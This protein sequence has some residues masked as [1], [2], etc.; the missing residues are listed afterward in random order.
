[1]FERLP[2]SSSLGFF[3]VALVSA[4]GFVGCSST[5]L[6]PQPHDGEIAATKLG[7]AFPEQAAR[8]LEAGDELLVGPQG[9]VR[10]PNVLPRGAVHAEL[11][12]DGSHPIVLRSQGFE[13]RVKQ[14]GV[15]SEGVL[16]KRA[17]AYR[18]AGGTSYWTVSAEGAEEWLD[19]S[20]E[21]V[22]SDLPVASWEIEGGVLRQHEDLIEVLDA[23]GRARMRVTAP[24]AYG[25]DNREIATRLEGQGTT[26]ALYVDADGEDVLV[27]PHWTDA[28]KM[29]TARVQHTMTLLSSGKV[30]VVGGKS[31]TSDATALDTAEIYDPTVNTWTR[32]SSGLTARRA[33]TATLLENGKVL[34]VGGFPTF[35]SGTGAATTS[36]Q[37]YD[38]NGDSWSNVKELSAGRGGH[39]S[40]WLSNDRVMVAGGMSGNT[41]ASVRLTAVETYNPATNSWSSMGTNLATGRRF[42]TMMQVAD[43]T[44]V[45]AG[46]DTSSSPPTATVD[47]YSG[48]SRLSNTNSMLAGRSGHSAILL[49]SGKI[50]VTNGAV[51]GNSSAFGEVFTPPNTWTK[52][53]DMVAARTNAGAVLLDDDKVLVIGGGSGT[54]ALSSGEVYDPDSNGWTTFDAALKTARR[55]LKAV[56]LQDGR[57]LVAGGEDDAGVPL[58]SVEILDFGNPSCDA[59][60]DCSGHGTCNEIG[61]CDCS[62]GYAGDKCQY[63]D[64]TTCSGHGAAQ[65]DG[66]CICAS[67]YAGERCEGCG[68]GYYGYPN[69]QALGG[70]GAAC[71][72][73]YECESGR[74][75]DNRCCDSA[76]TGQCEA[77]DLPGREG[78]CSAVTGAPRHGRALCPDDDKGCAG[79][80]DGAKRNACSHPITDCRA[81]TDAGADADIDAGN[82]AGVPEDAGV[83]EDAGEPEDASAGDDAGELEDASA[84]ND[85]GELEDAS[86]GDDAGELEDA[87]DTEDAS[88]DAGEDAAPVDAGDGLDAESDASEEDDG[89]ALDAGADASRDAATDASDDSDSG[90][91]RRTPRG[92]VVAA[93]DSGCGCRTAGATTSPIA[94]WWSALPIAAV[95]ARRRQKKRGVENL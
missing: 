79:Y 42:P 36:V 24:V 37:I 48:T 94:W 25:K 54:V 3:F 62:A 66:S 90:R 21:H 23:K 46:G 49:K 92:D 7:L 75:V 34:V 31:T 18:R 4:S 95:F 59:A 26:L 6:S 43:G 73:A 51:A 78:I 57:V 61:R 77:C 84:D 11:P 8:V 71:A 68:H 67:G 56:K 2:R 65:A 52:T 87:G 74:C 82:D 27:D 58:D 38:P 30:L 41:G 13:L 72:M 55:G 40:V 45:I 80:C 35:P 86:A 32:T 33:H 81:E 10:A 91:P 93:S 12:R 14:L 39:G 63:N 83:G 64:I 88:L 76:C 16:A 60:I 89:G 85:A 5:E 28:R 9:F 22:R 19:L 50:L 69:C 1:M 20:A 70:Q 53:G 29:T 15:D 47:R 17:V 44:V